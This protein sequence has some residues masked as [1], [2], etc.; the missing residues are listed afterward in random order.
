LRRFP[1]VL[2]LPFAV[3][4]QVYFLIDSKDTILSG[5]VKATPSGDNR[6]WYIVR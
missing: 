1:L 6:S 5:V 2:T 3:A 4:A